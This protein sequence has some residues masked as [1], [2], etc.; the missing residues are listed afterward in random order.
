MYKGN[1]VMKELL[2]VESV[3]KYF[4]AKGGNLLRAVDDVSFSVK[5]GLVFGLVGESGCGKSTL[6]RLILRLILPTGGKIFFDG[7]D[8]VEAR[9]EVL[10][11]IRKGLQIVFQDPFAS[12]NPRRRVIDTIGEA[13]IVNK[14]VK[15]GEAKDRVV[16]LLKK[17]GLNG[18]SLYKY[19]HELSGG[20]R[21]RVCIARALAVN[22]KLIVADEP[23]SALDVSI[24]AQIINLLE[25]LQKGSQLSYVFISHNLQ[26]IEHFSDVVAVM[27]LGKI[28]EFGATEELFEEPLHPYTEALLSAAPKI[29]V[30]GKGKKIILEGDIPSPLNI[31]SG[32]PFHPRCPKRFEPCDRVV[33]AFKE[34]SSER[35]VSCHLWG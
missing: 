30:E 15:K 18:D 11:K 1:G 34:V 2:R 17:V 8:V 31:P 32:C 10:S 16:E 5:E 6:A 24:Q 21:Q 3:R 25:E 12:L 28:V 19:P 22:P 33:P 26:V 20:Q 7:L 14:I 13:L 27:Y 9:G 35:W 4:P 29:G 23:L